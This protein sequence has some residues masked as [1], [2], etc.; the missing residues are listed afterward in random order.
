MFLWFETSRCSKIAKH[1]SDKWKRMNMSRRE[2]KVR[3]I[4]ICLRETRGKN[5]IA[6]LTNTKPNTNT[7]TN[8]TV[9]RNTNANLE[10]SEQGSV[11]DEQCNFDK[12]LN[13]LRTTGLLDETF[14]ISRLPS[15][16]FVWGSLSEEYKSFTNTK[17]TV[18]TNTNANYQWRC[19][20]W[21]G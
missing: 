4:Q 19:W 14:I 13:S 8:T 5:I 16:S 9:D 17:R 20:Q 3:P 11:S 18:D 7:N 12:K 15:A 2:T 6:L 21:R 1:I 10:R